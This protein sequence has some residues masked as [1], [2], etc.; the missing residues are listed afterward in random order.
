[1]RTEKEDPGSQGYVESWEPGDTVQGEGQ[2]PSA[3]GAKCKLEM[4]CGVGAGGLLL[5]SV[6]PKPRPW[7]PGRG[8][9]L[10]PEG[11][12]YP[13]PLAPP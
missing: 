5:L 6:A 4:L 1:M 12:A 8:Q 3:P 7:K 11:G 9:G 2:V 13:A 10:G